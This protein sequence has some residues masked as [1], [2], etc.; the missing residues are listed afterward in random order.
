MKFQPLGIDLHLCTQIVCLDEFPLATLPLPSVFC[1]SIK[2]FRDPAIA[3][4]VMFEVPFTLDVDDHATR[5]QLDIL[6]SCARIYVPK[7]RKV[8]LLLSAPLRKCHM[9]A[10][11]IGFDVARIVEAKLAI[12][13]MVGK[14]LIQ[15]I[16]KP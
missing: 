7:K 12:Q 15:L 2:D 14:S 5:L 16:V 11:H 3:L 13:I 6:Y 1:G 10:L 9:F 8:L 4:I